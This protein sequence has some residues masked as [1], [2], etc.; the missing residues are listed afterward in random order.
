MIKMTSSLIFTNSYFLLFILLLLWTNAMNDNKRIRN[1][2]L[3]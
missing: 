2:N 1:L 3:K